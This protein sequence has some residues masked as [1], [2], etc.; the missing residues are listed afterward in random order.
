[1]RTGAAEL[2]AYAGRTVGDAGTHADVDAR[3]RGYGTAYAVTLS[4]RT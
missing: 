3:G 4:L 1:M 2:V